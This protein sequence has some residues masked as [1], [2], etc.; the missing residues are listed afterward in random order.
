MTSPSFPV[1][2]KSSSL[3]AAGTDEHHIGTVNGRR[4]FDNPRFHVPGRPPMLL[5]DVNA[6]NDHPTFGRQNPQDFPGPA[7]VFA[8]YHPDHIA[9]LNMNLP[10]GQ[11]P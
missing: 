9:S 2:P 7:P 8:G 3:V 5:D 1:N 11:A 6:L 10:Y 4:L